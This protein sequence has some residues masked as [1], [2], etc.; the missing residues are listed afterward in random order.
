LAAAGPAAEGTTIT[1][2]FDPNKTEPAWTVFVRKFDRRY[3]TRPDI[4]AGYAYDGA[5]L[6][7]DAIRAQGPNRYRIRDALTA[8]KESEGVTGHLRFDPAQNNLAPLAVARVTR[9]A[10]VFTP[11]AEIGR[12]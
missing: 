11:D 10:F 9:G 2:P 1:Y 12:R 3:G 6:L 5:R 8:L 4:Y 7:L